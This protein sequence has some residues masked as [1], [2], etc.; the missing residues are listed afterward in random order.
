[1]EMTT[2]SL[3]FFLRGQ[4]YSDNDVFIVVLHVDNTDAEFLDAGCCEVQ[5]KQGGVVVLSSV[6]DDETAITREWARRVHR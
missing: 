4:T 2:F 3:S 1:M 5:V 6:S